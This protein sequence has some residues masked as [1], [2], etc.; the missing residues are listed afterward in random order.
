MASEIQTHDLVFIQMVIS[1]WD[2]QNKRVG[3]LINSLTDE[4][5]MSETAPRRNRGIYLLGHLTA[6]SDGMIPI[7]GWGQRMY[8]AL[9]EPFVKQPD[10]AV[11]SIPSASQLRKYWSEVNSRVSNHIAEMKPA[12]W[13]SRHTLVSEE[14][15]MKEPHRNK[16]NI[17][18]NRANHHSYHLGQMIYLSKRKDE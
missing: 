18:V 8:P 15:F 10:R 4:Q 2:T 1:A 5:L 16:L 17:L 11:S 6:V 7:L 13:F 9:E 3:D 14:A 12:D